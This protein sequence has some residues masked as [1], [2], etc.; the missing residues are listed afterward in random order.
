[1]NPNKQH[2]ELI[3][4]LVPVVNEKYGTNLTP[5][6]IKAVI[7]QESGW[8]T[9]ARS[10]V[11]A[12]G[13]MQLMPDTANQLNPNAD[14]EDP[15]DNIAMGIT[16]LAI[17]TK[18]HNNDIA[19][20]LAS[21]NYGEGNI[22][23]MKQKYGDN[24]FSYLP[25]E[26]KNY[27]SNI[28][29]DVMSSGSVDNMSNTDSGA[30]KYPTPEENG[31]IP[32]GQTP[33][34]E[35]Y[36]KNNNDLMLGLQYGLAA[37]GKA[38]DTQAQKE[39]ADITSANYKLGRNLAKGGKF[40]T[41]AGLDTALTYLSGGATKVVGPL[42]KTAIA[43]AK[44]GPIGRYTTRA[45]VGGGI[46]GSSN[47]ITNTA[48]SMFAPKYKKENEKNNLL[49]AQITGAL[50]AGTNMIARYFT[51]A[52]T[53]KI[54]AE[55]VLGQVKAYAES[56]GKSVDELIKEGDKEL[57]NIFKNI[58]DDYS[59]AVKPFDDIINGK[60][61]IGTMSKEAYQ[62]L[63]DE[64]SKKTK[65][66]ISNMKAA[67]RQIIA[68]QTKKVK[69]PEKLVNAL[70][71]IQKNAVAT[72]NAN[73]GTRKVAEQLDIIINNAGLNSKD[74]VVEKVSTNLPDWKIVPTKTTQTTVKPPKVTEAN[75]EV[76]V[77]SIKE[78]KALMS[79]LPDA[80]KYA[81]MLGDYVDEI[82]ESV[83][84]LKFA[85]DVDDVYADVLKGFGIDP[86]DAE[87]STITKNV[88]KSIADPSY[89]PSDDK[90]VSLMDNPKLRMTSKGTP[91][92]G[93]ISILN[94]EIQA[95]RVKEAQA[96]KE[97]VQHQYGKNK[98]G[99]GTMFKFIEDYYKYKTLPQIDKL[100][101]VILDSD[102]GSL[103]GNLV[104]NKK[105]LPQQVEKAY[106]NAFAKNSKKVADLTADVGTK[107]T[108]SKSYFDTSDL[109]SAKNNATTTKL[110]EAEAAATSQNLPNNPISGAMNFF[111]GKQ[112]TP[113][114]TN[115]YSMHTSPRDVVKQAVANQQAV[116]NAVG[117]N[118]SNTPMLNAAV[119]E[120]LAPS[121]IDDLARESYNIMRGR[122]VTEAID[123]GRGGPFANASD[124]PLNQT[125]TDNLL[126]KAAI[127]SSVQPIV[128]P[129]AHGL[130]GTLSTFDSILR[131]LF[132]G[133]AAVNERR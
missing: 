100:S 114:L 71:L 66:I 16:H 33:T 92:E 37:Q 87:L 115:A 41:E 98:S 94:P 82:T 14:P 13:L 109:L 57:I 49:Q 59:Q 45:A 84:S 116:T 55:N 104:Q 48:G 5:N 3:E 106:M 68:D 65:P 89:T 43:V 52:G 70:K 18:L 113:V 132:K 23:K 8:N 91:L 120:R 108:N 20:A 118:F 4:A 73:K 46:A 81:D 121:K 39:G 10:P 95:Q 129:T 27:V 126:R 74:R 35:Q 62:S 77:N 44:G 6:L 34:P 119:T 32:Q 69:L 127:F 99:A 124:M 26:P 50:G 38:S 79:E 47:L 75:A 112:H 131:P 25:D 93:K 107:F 17:Q 19:E 101:N 125:D 30:F 102:V 117:G 72:K 29:S 85:K 110:A 7:K 15:L 1:M 96:A 36:V 54:G 83:P 31:L 53:K 21:Y 42:A 2:L 67:G 80:K 90:L 123:Q 40:L 60:V 133:N 51:D 122:N 63:V 12:I 78:I 111:S 58:S 128:A 24:Y 22:A 11:G 105:I 61:D 76:I 103:I 28:L 130:P 64:V 9:S 56:A 86:T 97:L 88:K